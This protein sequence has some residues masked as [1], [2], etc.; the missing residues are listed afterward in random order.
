M[1]R[2]KSESADTKTGV[3]LQGLVLGAVA[4]GL[5]LFLAATANSLTL[6]ADFVATL[7]GFLVMG[8]AWLGFRRVS[9]PSRTVSDYGF[10]KFE[11]ISSIGMAV[12]MVGSCFCILGVAAIRFLNPVPVAGLGVWIGIVLHLIFGSM[13]GRLLLKTLRLERMGKTPLL[14]SQKQFFVIKFG[15]NALIIAALLV[16]LAFRSHRWAMYADPVVA[17]LIAVMILLNATKTVRHSVRDLLDCALEEQSQLLILRAL[18]THFDRYEH[19]HNIRTRLAG[20]KV[21]VEL[22]LEFDGRLPHARVMETVQ[23]LQSE[24]R[25]ALHCDEVLIIPVSPARADSV[26]GDARGSSCVLD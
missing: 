22:F 25:S 17:T 26:A 2:T 21:Y 20:G 16:S 8:V 15:S 12:L 23:D 13:N 1:S 19:L 24:I 10:G 6:W 5:S 7:L 3:A 4:S 14:S 9:D 18:A 11:S